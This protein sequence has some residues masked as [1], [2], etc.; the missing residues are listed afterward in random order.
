[1]SLPFLLVCGLACTAPQQQPPPAAAPS[2]T[3]SMP[4][5]DV[6]DFDTFVGKWNLK[7]R[8]LK[9]RGVGSND[10]DEFPADSVTT[11]Y[12]GGMVN[13]DE[14]HFPTKGWSGVTVRVFNPE[15]R[16]WTIFWVSSRRGVMDPGQ[17]GGFTG[18]RGEFYGEDDDDGHHVKV[19]YLWTK[20]K[21]QPLH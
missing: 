12:L 19:R 9:A 13:V 5:G 15:K 4:Q 21:E 6:H 17:V 18:D 20:S 16:Q 1:R 10:W 14:V 11:Q 7:N 3:A 8:R 2:S